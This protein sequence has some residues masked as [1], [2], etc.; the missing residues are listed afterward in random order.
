MKTLPLILIFILPFTACSKKPI[1]KSEP[2][3]QES[4]LPYGTPVAGKPGFITSP[5][6]PNQ[7]Y[8][9]V[10][11]FAPNVEVKDPYSGKIFLT[12]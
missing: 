2:A 8:I 11:G 7:G 3:V 6:S 12:P 10:R 9:D 5:Y 4:K 1:A